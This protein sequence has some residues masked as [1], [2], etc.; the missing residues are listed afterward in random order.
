M[1]EKPCEE[2]GDKTQI[3]YLGRIRGKLLCKKC[4]SSVRKNHREETKNQTSEDEREKIRE[5]SKKQK[6]EY[7]EAYNKKHRKT[8]QQ[9]DKTPPKIK[10][11]KLARKKPKPN[12]YLTKEDKQQLFRIIMKR[13]LTYEE[14]GDALDKLFEE[15]TRVREV[16]RYKNKSEEQIKIKQ[17]EML[18]ELWNS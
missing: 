11:S 13:G 2:C 12:S 7:N 4:R 14:A 5:L 16:M 18:E 17:Q 1:A 8:K 6:A 10:G 3:K 15:Q 9:E